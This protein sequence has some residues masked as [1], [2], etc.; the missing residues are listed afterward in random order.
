MSMNTW[1]EKNNVSQMVAPYSDKRFGSQGNTLHA[2]WV[3]SAP[4]SLLIQQPGSVLIGQK[5]GGNMD[6][7]K[8][9]R[10][11]LAVLAALMMTL[12]TTVITT[13]TG[14]VVCRDCGPNRHQWWRH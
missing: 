11:M 13:A 5:G 2:K 12:M 9:K 10:G 14:C 4:Q 6:K 8:M 3:F 7:L 1:G